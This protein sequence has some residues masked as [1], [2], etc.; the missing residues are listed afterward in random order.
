MANRP[1]NSAV[2]DMLRETADLL[3]RTEAN[4]HRV[5]AYRTAASSIEAARFSV[6]D[7]VLGGQPDTVRDLPGVGKA[8]ASSVSEIAQSG[9]LGLLERLRAETEPE[10]V[11]ASIPGV[12][13]KLARRLH[14]ELGVSSLEELEMASHD[15]RLERMQGVGP[16]RT[17]AIRETLNSRLSRSARRRLHRVAK[18]REEPQP[19]PVEAL[20]ETD[21]EY[22]RKAQ[23][24]QL[25][26]IAP[27]RFNPSGE[28]WLPIMHRRWGEWRLTAMFSNT[29]RAHELDKTHEWVVIYYERN[30][31]QNQCT[32]V[33][34][35]GHRVVRGR[36]L[37]SLQALER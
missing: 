12:G 6:A 4:P 18:G 3:E 28:A 30:G 33:N 27:K 1:S 2:A 13:P 17:D 14:E 26:T 5:R 8:I 7:R 21:D 23:A 32:V 19:P 16:R 37:E 10:Q 34:R 11:L 20:L 25:H 35:D 31:T 24:G 36:E 22:R 9:R 29:A 15:G